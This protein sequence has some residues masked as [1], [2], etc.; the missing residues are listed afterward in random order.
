M[1]CEEQIDAENQGLNNRNAAVPHR[2]SWADLRNNTEKYTSGTEKKEDFIRWTDR[3]IVAANSKKAV[4]AIAKV[5]EIVNNVNQQI[6][7]L[8]TERDALIRAVESK[9]ADISQEKSAFLSTLNSFYPNVP[10]SGPHKGVN[11]QV[12]NRAH[13]ALD[14]KGDWTPMSEQVLLMTPGR[15]EGGIAADSTGS[16]IV[17]THGDQILIKSL[18]NSAS[19]L[20]HKRKY[21]ISPTKAVVSPNW[22]PT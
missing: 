17:T 16:S 19:K 9:T 3:L 7:K 22:K 2:M 15:L 21:L 1:F 8:Q 6:Q 11:I 4:P 12:S 20:L 10:D 14:N 5:P 13:L 18:G